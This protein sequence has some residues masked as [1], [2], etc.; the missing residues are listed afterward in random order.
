MIFLLASLAIYLYVVALAAAPEP[1]EPTTAE[2]IRNNY[3]SIHNAR[4]Q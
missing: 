3:R 1:P 4:N 2:R